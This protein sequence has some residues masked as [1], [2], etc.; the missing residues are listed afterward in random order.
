MFWEGVYCANCGEL[1]GLVTPEFTPHIFYICDACH[2]KL[3]GLAPPGMVEGPAP[4][5]FDLVNGRIELT[6]KG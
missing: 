1:Q 3:N 6:E 5:G 4:P 2:K